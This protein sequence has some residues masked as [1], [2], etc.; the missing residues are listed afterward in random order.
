M[1]GVYIAGLGA[2]SPAGWNMP[3][4]RDALAKGQLLPSQELPRPGLEKP[5]RVMRVPPANPRPA[6]LSHARL[7]RTSPITQFAVAAALEALG[8]RAPGT[9]GDIGVVLCVFS[10]CVNYSRRFYD[11]TLKDPA[12]ASPLVFPETVFNAP[13]SHISAFLGSTAINYTLVGDS[14]TFLV[15]LATAARWLTEGRVSE[16]VVVGTE[17][18]DWL[19]SDAVRLFDRSKFLSEGAG[20]VLL[21]ASGPVQLRG[22][23]DEFLYG[24]RGKKTALALMKEE[25]CAQIAGTLPEEI[26]LCDSTSHASGISREESE[27]WSDWTGP[28]I[29][30]R[31]VLGE[32]LMAAAAWQLVAAADA[33]MTSPWNGAEAHPGTSQAPQD[34]KLASSP[35][36]ALVSIAGFHQQ[37]IG[38]SLCAA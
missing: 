18:V 17:E 32:G 29:S 13:A 28:R 24:A 1:S 12:T 19:T 10:G 37:A 23:T 6:F 5:L 4:L 38:A 22:V 35:R 2:V 16:C 21:K 30:P 15:G 3:A 26:L 36:E 33:L 34:K 25:L 8:E 31:K 11:E 27:F 7:R 9:T 14:G 20:A